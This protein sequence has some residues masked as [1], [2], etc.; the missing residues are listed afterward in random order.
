MELYYQS[1]DGINLSIS[2]NGVLTDPDSSAVN[3]TITRLLDNT[4]IVNNAAATRLS[5]GKYQYVL[6]TSDNS[7]LSQYKAVWSYTVNAVPNIKTTYYDVVVGYT[8]PQ[9]VR[10]EYTEL[11][12]Y[13]NDEIYRKEKIARKIINS[14]CGQTFDFETG[15]TKT[16][17]GK[18]SN[19]LQMPRRIW[20]LTQVNYDDA[21]TSSNDITSSVEISSDFYISSTVDTG[22]V[23]VKRDIQFARPFF[24]DGVRY[25]IQG[26]WGWQSVPDAIQTATRLLIRDYLDDDSLL[27]QHGV[28]IARMG[29][30]EF[31]FG[32]R[33]ATQTQF[34]AS[35]GNYDADILLQDYTLTSIVLI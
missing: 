31:E 18:N 8:S 27:R 17:V 23:D 29:D 3:V 24:I 32:G 16:V 15:V 14:F 26:D 5:A 13:S 11:A 25:F 22:F 30:R 1:S 21:L 9:D 20:G 35:T 4:V 28:S 34:W 7:T 12:S 33:T 19:S 10:D 6:T 2:I